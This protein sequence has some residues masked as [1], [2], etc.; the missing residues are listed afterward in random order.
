MTCLQGV[1]PRLVVG[2]AF[3]LAAMPAGASAESCAT[4]VDRIGAEARL[5]DCRAWEQVS[6]VD[7]K[8]VD[9]VNSGTVASVA[10]GDGAYFNAAGAFAGAESVLYDTAYL[11]TRGTD[12]AT[13]G[14]DPPLTPTGL[15]V[16]ATLGLSEDGTK[17]VV[18][19][20]LALAP[21]AKAGGSNLYIRDLRPGGGYRLVA[22]TDDTDLYNQLTGFGGQGNYVGGTDDL[23]AIAFMATTPLV[24]EAPG[25]G[26]RSLYL[27][28]DGQLELASRLPDGTPFDLRDYDANT[29][30]RL[31]RRLSADGTRVTF[32]S[33]STD[34]GARGQALYQY[35]SGHGTTLI[36]RSRVT[37]ADPDN[38]PAVT[39]WVGSR[40]GRTVT[41]QSATAL[42]NQS[43]VSGIYRWTAD[44]DD[45][46]D[47]TG[48]YVTVPPEGAPG[49]TLV[50]ASDDG[51]Y[52]WIRAFGGPMRASDG[53][54]TGTRLY[55]LDTVAEKL[56]LISDFPDE[57]GG[58]AE[59][60][61]SPN[62]HRIAFQSFASRVGG[63][64]G[65]DV[66]D[67]V[68]NEPAANAP[69]RCGQIYAYDADAPAA[70]VRCVSCGPAGTTQH[71]L[72]ASFGRLATTFDGRRSRAIL[73]DG[74]IFFD[75][76]NRLVPGDTNDVGDVYQDTPGQGLSLLSSGVS[77]EPASFGD[78]SPDGR[79]VFFVTADRLVA[80]DT[81]ALADLYSARTGGGI[82]SQRVAPRGA[83]DGCSGESCRTAP[84]A[85]PAR[86]EPGS[87]V[88]DEP[89]VGS[90]PRL[91]VV[92]PSASALRTAGRRGRLV[93]RVNVTAPG[94]VRATL[95]GRFPGRAMRTA[96]KATTTAKQA[97][98][99]R[100]TLRLSA[101]AR[102]VL[103]RKGR[104][105]LRLTV[106]YPAAAAEQQRTLT[107]TT[108]RKA[109][110]S[111]G[112][113]R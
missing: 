20:S 81:D 15:L 27:W 8:G 56:R 100:L 38:P 76:A 94:A 53:D 78:S 75:S 68:C 33:P 25:D 70:P 113:T 87:A 54:G 32:R 97:G 98:A 28:R 104:L 35:E 92:R 101:S 30:G 105:V 64:E 99:V 5:P 44:G 47:L 41:F 84:V 74:R 61:T 95:R 14:T 82:P 58:P 66:S 65:V 10:G 40:D 107:F 90:S 46:V 19:T 106:A 34:F 110:S 59:Y 60:R 18:V 73:D 39:F 111:K 83:G 52:V 108:G 1:G 23:S 91:T 67:P 6:P 80:Q 72:A 13:R 51:R 12:W 69:G 96:A 112:G 71:R 2:A 43:R 50:D 88:F 9:V 63:A 16:K 21:G 93:L 42:T 86:P 22:A 89:V 37:G 29:P 103:R 79:A 4:P 49:L 77:A 3:A 24:A 26:A 11:A 109:T 57:D 85:P 17:A 55:V 48:A 31:Q 7:K 36:G 102:K 45:L 62:G